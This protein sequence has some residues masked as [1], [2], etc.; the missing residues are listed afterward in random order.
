M[1][2]PVRRSRAEEDKVYLRIGIKRIDSSHL[3]DRFVELADSSSANLGILAF[4]KRYGPLYLCDRHAL[5]SYHMSVRT[6]F[7]AFG[8]APQVGVDERLEHC[9]CGPRL[10]RH[11]PVTFSEPIQVWRT[12]ARRIENLLLVAG[13]VRIEG[14]AAPELWEKADGFCGSFA[15]GVMVGAGPISTT[16]G[17]FFDQERPCR[18]REQRLNQESRAQSWDWTL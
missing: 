10:E 1:D 17:L 4:A 15:Q 5:A 16:R 18:R 2:V 14:K 7:N 11:S 8:P 6:P 13:A 12:F 3:L 9:W